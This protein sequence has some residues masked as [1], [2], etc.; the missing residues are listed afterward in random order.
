[1]NTFQL[2]IIKDNDNK[3]I[4]QIFSKENHNKSKISKNIRFNATKHNIRSQFRKL[5]HTYGWRLTLIE[6]YIK[7]ILRNNKIKNGNDK[8]V[9][10]NLKYEK[11]DQNYKRNKIIIDEEDGVRLALLF[12]TACRI[13]KMGKIDKI[14]LNLKSLS[15][16]E[17]YYWYS[18]VFNN[19]RKQN[20]VRALRILMVS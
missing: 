11:A 5:A 1:M 20:G 10:I 17:A 18:K 6:P 3:L 15:R 8:N 14:L 12:K 4:Y 16:E 2:N 19:G 9:Q 7:E 13:R